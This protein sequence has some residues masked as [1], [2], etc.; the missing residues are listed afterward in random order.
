[1][2]NKDTKDAWWKPAVF[3]FAQVSAWVAIPVILALFIGRYFDS[4][5]NTAPWIFIILTGIAFFISLLGIWK[6]LTKYI[7]EIEKEAKLKNGKSN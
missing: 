3:M 7:D 1:M 6:I 5:Y 2:D 4:K